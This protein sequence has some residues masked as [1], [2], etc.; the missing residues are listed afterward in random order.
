MCVIKQAIDR[1]Q[2]LALP[3]DDSSNVF[4]Q[5]FAPRGSDYTGATR[6]RED[7]VQ[8]NLRAGVGHFGQPH[9]ALLAE[10]IT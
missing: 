10:L 9:M 2:F 7:N 8:I 6:D 1:N 3:R 4:L 5:I